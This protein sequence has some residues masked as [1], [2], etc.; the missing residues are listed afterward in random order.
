MFYKLGSL[1]IIVLLTCVAC[2]H[3]STKGNVS[4]DTI[5]SDIKIGTTTM[6][7][8][9]SMLGEPEHKQIGM[10][11]VGIENWNYSYHRLHLDVTPFRSDRTN[12]QSKSLR[13]T[14]NKGVVSDCTIFVS[15]AS[16]G[17]SPSGSVT[18]KCGEQSIQQK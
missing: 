10:Q 12:V 6:P 9:L 14:F 11:G 2:T 1:F 5:A 16:G 15:N 4:L 7:Q 13:L 18:K 17:S 3:N 8:V